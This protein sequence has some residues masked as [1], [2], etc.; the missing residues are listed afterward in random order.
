[1][2]G[3]FYLPWT[4]VPV[5]VIIPF[6]WAFISS[7]C[8]TGILPGVFCTCR[9]QLLQIKNK[10]HRSLLLS[11]LQSKS[12][13]KSQINTVHRVPSLSTSEIGE[14][15]TVTIFIDNKIQTLIS[16]HMISLLHLLKNN[17]THTFT[18][19]CKLRHSFNH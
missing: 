13:D 5:W 10:K 16:S 14:K 17:S 6:F 18:H 15:E 4:W 2:C 12:L 9:F 7:S 19:S 1:M 11:T 8:S 3:C